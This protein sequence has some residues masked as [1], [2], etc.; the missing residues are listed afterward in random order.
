MSPAP[1]R[2]AALAMPVILACL[3]A[4]C[5]FDRMRGG[6]RVWYRGWRNS[7]IRFTGWLILRRRTAEFRKGGLSGKLHQA[8]TRLHHSHP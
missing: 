6:W 4:G 5:Q 2:L 3:R 1:A 7:L 8:Q